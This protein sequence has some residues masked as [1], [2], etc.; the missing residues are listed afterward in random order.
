MDPGL[1]VFASGPGLSRVLNVPSLG[2]RVG[3]V[4]LLVRALEHL[5]PR[6]V[7]VAP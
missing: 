1:P 6:Q 7:L 2:W 4:L 3:H 5:T